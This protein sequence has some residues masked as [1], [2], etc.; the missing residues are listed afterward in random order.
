MDLT[1]D[2]LRA[3]RL[4]ELIEVTVAEGEGTEDSP[5]RRVYY[6]LTKKGYAIARVDELAMDEEWRS[7]VPA[8]AGLA[9][10]N[11]GFLQV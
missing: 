5:V 7:R 4:V 1:S 2:R 11:A 9:D 10:D 3:A 6:Y 8:M